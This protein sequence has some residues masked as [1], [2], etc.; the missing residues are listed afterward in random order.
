MFQFWRFLSKH[1]RF[2]FL[3]LKIAT[4]AEVKRTSTSKISSDGNSG[5][6]LTDVAED[7]FAEVFAFWVPKLI[8]IKWAL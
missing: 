3:I 7:G 5:A 6:G 4:L 2:F 1:C 8:V